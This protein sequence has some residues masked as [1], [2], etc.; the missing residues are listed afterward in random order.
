MKFPI[1]LLCLS[2]LAFGQTRID[3]RSQS[4]EVDFSQAT[5]TRPVKTGTVL[6]A[7]CSV[8]EM[9]FKTDAG[10]GQNIYLCAGVN[11]WMGLAGGVASVFGRSGGVAAAEG[12]YSL[13][14]L[15][16]VTAK[17]G[18]STTVQMSGG[19]TPAANDCAKF[20]ANRNIV[21]AGAA[22][23]SGGGGGG[24][25]LLSGTGIVLTTAGSNT[26]VAL[27]TAVVPSFLS[28]QVFLSFGSVPA[29]S[30]VELPMTVSGAAE[31][32]SV[33]PGWPTGLPAGLSGTMFVPLADTV[34]V[35]LCN[36]TTGAVSVPS[37]TYRATILRSF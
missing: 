30:C 21:S 13:T 27:D 5:S 22:C 4:K 16:D 37:F 6:P 7:I 15:S 31:N 32:N 12:D 10:A 17:Q 35:R 28:V 19:G 34:R 8:G 2:G 3:L 18:N 11:T 29:Q 23:G 33:A 24:A 26:T 1:L 36:S 14:L 9:Y 20:D 25:N